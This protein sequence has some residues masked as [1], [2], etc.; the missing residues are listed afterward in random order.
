MSAVAATAILALALALAYLV[1]RTR[2]RRRD[3]LDTAL[4]LLFAAPGTVLGVGLILVWNRPGFGWLYGSAAIVLLGWIAH[5]TPLAIRAVGVAL[6][7][8]PRGLEEAARL[9]RA[10]WRRT[11]AR[12]LVPAVGPALA[13]AWLLAFI[14]CLRDLDL[15]ITIYPPGAE[16]LPVRVYTL[17]ANSP[18]SVV[19]ALGVL[20]V[21]LTAL[22]VAAGAG[23]WLAVRRISAR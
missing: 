22:V 13:G 4:L 19:A 21:G 14:F 18:E 15:A 6:G 8:V 2:P 1:E 5:F 10:S 23:G 20:T 11:V 9:A 12:V 7:A 17:M 16:T 3:G